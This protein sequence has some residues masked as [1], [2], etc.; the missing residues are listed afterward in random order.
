M[1]RAARCLAALAL[2]LGLVTA[3]RADEAAQKIVRRALD[4]TGGPRLARLR[5]VR[6]KGRGVLHGPSGPI[7]YTDEI[8]MQ[9]PDRARSTL[10]GEVAGMKVLIVTVVN[11]NKAWVQLN[12]LT[13]A[14]SKGRLDE[15]REQ[16]YAD[17]VAELTDLIGGRFRLTALGE[18]T[19]PGGRAVLGVK[20]S[21]KGHRDVRLFFDKNTGLLTKREYLLKDDNNHEIKQE[22][23]FRDYQLFAGVKKP[24]HIEVKRDGHPYLE[25]DVTSYRLTE[26]LDDHLF[27]EP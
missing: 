21:S 19:L 1:R 9:R 10:R 6:W 5:A 22:T 24:T 18:S 13:H 27:E 20:V 11:G 8:A 16:R 2:V 17:Y 3:I 25:E 4:A 15:A 12:H 7:R 26:K 23:F 14:L